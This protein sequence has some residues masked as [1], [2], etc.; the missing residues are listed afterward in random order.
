MSEEN[1]DNLINEYINVLARKVNDLSLELVMAQTKLNL[2]AK[3]NEIL[4]GQVEGLNTKNSKEESSVN[5]F[6]TE[7]DEEIEKDFEY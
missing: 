3:E 6:E 5:D 7:K 4:K 1:N 2:F